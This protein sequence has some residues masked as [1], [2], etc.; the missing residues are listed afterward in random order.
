M[1]SQ[2]HQSIQAKSVRVAGE[3]WSTSFDWV[4][5]LKTWVII[6]VLSAEAHCICLW[7]WL[8]WRSDHSSWQI[9]ISNLVRRRFLDKSHSKSPSYCREHKCHVP[10]KTFTKALN[11]L[12]LFS[13]INWLCRGGT[14]LSAGWSL[15]TDWLCSSQMI[16]IRYC[17]HVHPRGVE[18]KCVNNER[19]DLST[20]CCLFCAL[21]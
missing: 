19:S 14:A 17:G 15:M 13:E 7:L 2:L 8:W 21:F 6:T 11:D 18:M 5:S 1:N 9:S 12:L 16:E 3:W 20:L 10:R 4:C